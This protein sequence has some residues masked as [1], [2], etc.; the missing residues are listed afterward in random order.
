MDGMFISF[1]KGYPYYCHI[2]GYSFI[3]SAVIT[4]NILMEHGENDYII[5]NY[6]H[7]NDYIIGMILLSYLG[8]ITFDFLQ[9]FIS[10]KIFI[11]K[12]FLCFKLY[13]FRSLCITKK[14]R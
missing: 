5:T 3:R 4:T 6:N 12:I 1:K 9:T 13:S 2:Y 14:C 7:H 10:G 8:N 11:G